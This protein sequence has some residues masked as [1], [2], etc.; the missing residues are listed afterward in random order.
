MPALAG[1]FVALFSG[2][3]SLI[4]EMF[5]KYLSKKAV[6]G[7]A[8]VTTFGI[9]T[10]GFW[11]AISLLIQALVGSVPVGPVLIGL[12]AMIPDSAPGVVSAVLAADV[13]VT[14]Y[15]WNVKNLEIATWV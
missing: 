3:A 13:A 9:L 6:F 1:L 8:A 4:G 11:L 14:I 15:K 7:T 10:T 12:W 5:G 2:L